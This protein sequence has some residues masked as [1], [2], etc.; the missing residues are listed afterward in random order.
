M[1]ILFSKDLIV[2]G[3]CV[4][5]KDEFGMTYTICYVGDKE[6]TLDTNNASDKVIRR[7]LPKIKGAKLMSRKDKTD[8]KDDPNGNLVAC[9]SIN[10]QTWDISEM[11]NY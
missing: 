11:Y 3:G 4:R 7:V 8:Y 10:C 5:Y 9:G 6:I 2:S 1:E